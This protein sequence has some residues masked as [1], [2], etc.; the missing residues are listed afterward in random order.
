M[1]KKI[2]LTVIAISIAIIVSLLFLNKNDDITVE[3]EIINNDQKKSIE[4]YIPEDSTFLKEINKIY[5]ITIEDGFLYKIDFLDL[6]NDDK[7]YIAIYINDSY[8]KYGISNLKLNDK[9]KVSFIYTV[10]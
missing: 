4:L 10:L 2:I 3:V 7:A 8:S 1:I 9:D 6:T 5:D